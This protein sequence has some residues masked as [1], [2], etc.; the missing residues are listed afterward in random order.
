VVFPRYSD[1][2]EYSFVVPR[3]AAS[4]LTVAAALNFRRYRQEF[5]DLV[6]PTMEAESGVLQPT[7]TQDR[8]T[9]RIPVIAA[10]LQVQRTLDGN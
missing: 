10:P 1:N 2:Q 6:V 5:L 3:T 4:P 7:V 9:R 8:A